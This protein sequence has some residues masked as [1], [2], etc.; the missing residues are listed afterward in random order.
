MIKE[1][2]MKALKVAVAEYNGGKSANAAVVKAAEEA[3]FNDKQT[4]RL[5]EMFNTLAVL[6]KE[7]DAED[8]AGNCELASKEDVAKMLLSNGDTE[9]T[10]SAAFVPSDSD[11]SFYG[12]DPV[13]TNPTMEARA[14]GVDSMVKAAF[15]RD[16]VPE[17]LNVS[18]NSLFKIITNQ[19]ETV[20]EAAD[21][22]DDVVR[23]LAIDIDREAV[24][25]ARAIEHP[26]ADPE[27]ADMF[28]AACSHKNAVEK[29][30][31]FSDKVS[32]STGGR[33]ALLNVFDASP[34]E[35][36]LKI[37]EEIERNI[38]LIPEY[39]R[40]RDFYR[41]KAAEAEKELMAAVG[42]K[43]PE[44][45]ESGLADFFLKDAGVK[46]ASANGEEAV[47][48]DTGD[49]TDGI[50]VGFCVK[51]ANIL[52]ESGICSEAAEKLAE[53]LEKEAAPGMLMSVPMPSLEEAHGA[54]ASMPGVEN[55]RKRVMNARRAV[56]LADL[57]ANDP[58]IR[59]ADPDTV[60]EA[61]KTMVMTSPRVSLDKAQ[62]R[63]F[64]RS[65]VNSVAISPADAKIIADV[66]R[67]VSI[68]NVD[69]LSALDSSIK[70]S[71]IA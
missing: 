31:G 46:S 33:F 7:K 64:L 9:K 14:S 69:R 35:D 68:S 39:E 45:K 21:A 71:N 40:K 55:E 13:K 42:L 4:D 19:I 50:D 51:M 20:K 6:N 57:M 28:K 30:A 38:G 44:K 34:V 61:Y 58:I 56:L 27:L 65:A 54:L 62:A 52:R 11:Y 25:I 26:Y 3:D 1:K 70:D 29:V 53:D 66:D 22:A 59:D 23:Q 5:V 41:M 8:P 18:Q 12:S 67:G 32:E 47:S 49:D 24:K 43:V 37:A 15:A 60:V 36:M 10:A 16:E 17:E 2:L 63:A 48:K